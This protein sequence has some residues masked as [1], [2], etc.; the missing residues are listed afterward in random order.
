MGFLTFFDSD[1]DDGDE[2][3]AAKKKE[4]DEK[5]AAR[6]AELRRIAREEA[7]AAI[8]EQIEPVKP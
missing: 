5:E 7:N 6:I 3:A 4:A 2:R 1:E 8:D